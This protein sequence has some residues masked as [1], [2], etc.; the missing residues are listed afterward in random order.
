MIKAVILNIICTLTSGALC[1]K[2]SEVRLHDSPH[3][4]SPVTW[5]V[6]K[7]TPLIKLEKKGLWYR[8]EDQDGETHWV[9]SQFVT[10]QFQCLSIKSKN[11]KIR[12]GP[13]SQYPLAF[14]GNAD[15][16]SSFK[17]LNRQDNWHQVEDD[18]GKSFWIHDSIAWRPVSVNAIGF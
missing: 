13:G 10:S 3:A 9:H 4:Q 5:T 18:W 12:M 16:Y 7:Y 6:G 11:A 14:Y 1:V 8:V 17:R 2:N 15:K